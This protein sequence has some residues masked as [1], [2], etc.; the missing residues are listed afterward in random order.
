MSLQNISAI[1][2]NSVTWCQSKHMALGANSTVRKYLCVFSKAGGFL[3]WSIEQAESVFSL[4]GSAVHRA[5]NEKRVNGRICK[6][7]AW[8]VCMYREITR[9]ANVMVN[10]T[11]AALTSNSVGAM[12]HAQVHT[13]IH[14]VHCCLW[15]A[16]LRNLEDWQLDVLLILA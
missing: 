5:V 3:I 7:T 9:T 13:L 6:P 16:L 4:F 12:S 11:V 14:L 15:N 2:N 1:H 8:C 10:N